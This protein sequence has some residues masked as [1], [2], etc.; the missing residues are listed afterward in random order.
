MAARLQTRTQN[1]SNYS[2]MEGKSCKSDYIWQEAEKEV[3]HTNV[4]L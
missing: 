1:E 4:E 2:S 3:A